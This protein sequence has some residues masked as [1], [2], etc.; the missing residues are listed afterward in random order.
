MPGELK[1]DGST[2]VRQQIH[3]QLSTNFGGFINAVP[4]ESPLFSAGVKLE[5]KSSKEITTTVEAMDI[6]AEYI[7]P[8]DKFV[9]KVLAQESVISFAKEC[10]FSQS[11]FMIV[12]VATAG[13]LTIDEE[14]IREKSLAASANAAVTGT[15]T[16]LGAGIEAGKTGKVGGKLSVAK[17][18]DFAYRVREFEYRK[19][20]GKFQDKGDRTEGALF[21]DGDDEVPV[22]VGW[23]DEDFDG[24]EGTMFAL[25]TESNPEN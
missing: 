20:R 18:S 12:G 7:V 15:G 3:S 24:T 8:N 17:P 2:A 19:W 25:V 11:V 16:E 6:K 9:N 13:S 14:Q 22:F 5:G 4:P 1:L 10:N 21:A 23:A